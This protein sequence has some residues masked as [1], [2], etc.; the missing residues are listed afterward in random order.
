M[1]TSSKSSSI[2]LGVTGS[3]AAFKAAQLASDLKK[4][5][6]EVVVVLTKSA[7][8]FVG[9]ATFEALTHQ[10]VLVDLFDFR[11]THKPEHIDV[12]LH[13]SLI[14]VAPATANVIGK[15]ASGIADDLLTNIV[16]AAASPVLICPAMNDRMWKNPIVQNNVKT[17]GKLGYHFC[18]PDEGYLA[19]GYE[20]VGR[21][22][23]VDVIHE[24]I[25]KL[26]P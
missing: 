5:G 3:I 15:I 23:E 20:G 26:I 13:A 6:R 17:L 12:A 10:P 4:E 2:I 24:A 19:D 9:E 21:L 8:K 18:G 14:V 22:A 25:K 1:A 11:K 7:Q 16:M